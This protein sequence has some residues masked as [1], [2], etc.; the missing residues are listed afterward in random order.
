MKQQLQRRRCRKVVADAAAVAIVDNEIADIDMVVDMAVEMAVE[1]VV[2]M[3]VDY[4]AV[5]KVAVVRCR[6]W[7]MKAQSDN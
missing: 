2:G 5:D 7:K 6:N 4:V 3:P 1:M